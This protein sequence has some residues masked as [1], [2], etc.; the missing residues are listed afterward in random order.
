M[1]RYSLNLRPKYDPNEMPWQQSLNQGIGSAISQ[2]ADREAR[3]RAEENATAAEGGTQL[4]DQPTPGI[5]DRIRGIGSSIST[6]IHGQQGP[7]VNPAGEIT[8]AQR[9]GVVQTPVTP[10]AQMPVVPRVR[11]EGGYATP[12]PPAMFPRASLGA[13]TAPPNGATAARPNAQSPTTIG[14]AIKPYT[15]HGEF[16]NYSIDPLYGARVQAEAKDMVSHQ[17][18]EEQIASLVN[19]GMNPT[20]ARAKVLNNVVRYDEKFG[21]KSRGGSSLTYQQRL[22][23][24]DRNNA[25]RLQLGRMAAAGRQ[26]TAQYRQALLEQRQLEDQ[27]RA[28]EAEA[29]GYASEAAGVERQIPQGTNRIVAESQPGGTERIA[30]D[31]QRAAGLRGQ[32]RDI[33]GKNAQRFR[34]GTTGTAP[35]AG[36][37]TP[38][39]SQA[40]ALELKKQ[41]YSKSAAYEIMKREGHNVAPPK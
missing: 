6:M 12:N 38:E 16:H 19:A 32:A 18:E 21:Q 35:A 28:D 20:E 9:D 15:Y 27:L 37:F 22:D 41:G 17:H 14:Q 33:R 13:M 26:N 4:P 7:G 39:Q 36:T 31:A 24:L 34:T 29:R 3:R 25:V 40:R 30:A 1:P 5:M 11:T 2:Y 10:N 8:G 23:L